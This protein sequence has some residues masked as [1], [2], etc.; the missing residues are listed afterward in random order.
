MWFTLCSSETHLRHKFSQIHH[1]SL[2]LTTAPSVSFSSYRLSLSKWVK[3]HILLF[4]GGVCSFTSAFL[5]GHCLPRWLVTSRRKE[6]VLWADDGCVNRTDH[7][8]NVLV[9]LD[10][11]CSSSSKLLVLAF[12]HI[13][14]LFT[15]SCPI[16]ISRFV[17]ITW[18]SPTS[19]H[20]VHC[21][22]VSW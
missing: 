5:K 3:F 1:S 17:G 10:N 19:P 15:A 13:Q 20:L 9:F 7:I 22:S 11:N 8:P 2:D 14:L 18:P 16:W 6:F 4:K 21:E 12:P